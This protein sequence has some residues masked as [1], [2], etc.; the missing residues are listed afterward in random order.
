MFLTSPENSA[1]WSGATGYI[2]VNKAA[3]DMEE[4]Q[5]VVRETPAYAVARDQFEYANPQMMSINVEE[6][7]EVVKDNLNYMI[8]LVLLQQTMLILM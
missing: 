3:Y 1:K 2:A 6:V 8:K 5:E 4:M 7:R